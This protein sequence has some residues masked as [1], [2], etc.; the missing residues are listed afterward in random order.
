MAGIPGIEQKPFL[1]RE[2]ASATLQ[3]LL[4]V[5]AGVVA[6][7]KEKSQATPDMLFVWAAWCALAIAALC[8]I[9]R[10]VA[11][12]YK[13][14]KDMESASPAELAG[15]L[16]VLHRMIYKAKGF[17]PSDVTKLRITLHKV[18]GDNLVQL[19]DYVG[20]DADD[21]GKHGRTARRKFLIHSGIIGR[22]AR[23][24]VPRI[25][26]RLQDQSFDDWVRHL[27]EHL[28]MKDADARKTNPSRFAFMGVPLMTSGKVDAVVYFDA[29]ES[30]FFDDATVALVLEGCAGLST[31][32]NEKYK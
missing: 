14:K 29:T 4:P 32:A 10:V 11:A 27:V 24:C 28:G 12:Y 13:D 1:A 16:H 26:D 25:L 18:D 9:V 21:D 2:L 15:C 20:G 5:V 23:M 8:V 3:A 19:L 7:C 30:G 31:Y 22:V 6:L 17:D